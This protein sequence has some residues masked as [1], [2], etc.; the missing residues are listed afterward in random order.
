MNVLTNTTAEVWAMLN[1]TVVTFT[2][3]VT[4]TS[5]HRRPPVPSF[6]KTFQLR[7]LP[8]QRALF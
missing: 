8:H 2:A 4:P 1:R 3:A 7:L 6:S 5:A